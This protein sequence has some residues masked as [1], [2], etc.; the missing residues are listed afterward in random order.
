MSR[1]DRWNAILE[2]LAQ[3]GR[4][5]VEEAAGALDVSTATIRRD[6]DQL[7]QQQML[8]RTRGGAVA[9][10]VSYDLPLRYKTARHADEKHRIAQAAA[11]LVTP[12]AVIGMNGGTTTS[13][14]ART[15][16]T[17]ATLESGFTI[18]TNALNIA[19]ELTVRQHVKIVVTGGVARQ[20]SYELIGPLA[21]GVL[22]QVTLDVAF[23]GVDGLDVELGASAHHEGE[24]SVNHLLISRAAQVVVVADS[25]KIG[26]RAFS[27]ICP[28][29]QIDTLVTDAQLPDTLAGQLT[30]A[31]VKVVRA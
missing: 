18:V 12:G 11:E 10:S 21:G 13:E 8:M 7:A 28:I 25:S 4:L 23:L 16:A 9:Q 27:R 2:L 26:K 15:L 3:E 30:D 1:Y 29:G 31:G 17:Q 24:A 22:E 14:L 20:Q 19:A 5:S 6:F